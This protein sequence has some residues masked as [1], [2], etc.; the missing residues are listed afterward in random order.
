MV[1]GYVTV[2][3]ALLFIAIGSVVNLTY[4]QTRWAH[5]QWQTANEMM[6]LLIG[7]RQVHLIPCHFGLYFC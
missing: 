7:L 3:N 2:A 5:W 1:P 6:W 4:A